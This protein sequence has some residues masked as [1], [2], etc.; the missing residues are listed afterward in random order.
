MPEPPAT[1]TKPKTRNAEALAKK[2]LAFRQR[3]QVK[4]DAALIPASPAAE[5]PAVKQSTAK[6][7]SASAQE[8]AQC[9]S[10]LARSS[11]S[12]RQERSSMSQQ[13]IYGMMKNNA[14]K[15]LKNLVIL[16]AHVYSMLF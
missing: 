4:G 16:L 8:I 1:P 7:T 3:R 9:S 6:A 10:M 11:A 2:P 14:P 13:I 15:C 12:W 5:P